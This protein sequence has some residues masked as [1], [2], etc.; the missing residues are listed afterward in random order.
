MISRLHCLFPLICFVACERSAV[1][2][3]TD[4]TATASTTVATTAVA[5]QN[6]PLSP[7]S[8][9]K[10]EDS[11]F[12]TFGIDSPDSSY[13]AW[14]RDG[15]VSGDHVR[16]PSGLLIIWLDTAVRAADGRPRR[17]HADSI[18]VAGLDPS[19]GLARFC[20]VNGNTS[21]AV[22]L[23]RDTATNHRPRLAWVFDEKTFRIKPTPTDSLVCFLRD[24]MEHDE[25][26]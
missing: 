6:V 2:Q 23:V 26:D 13:G 19:E 25:V 24:P 5:T 14:Y 15:F 22:G 20:A 18:V 21:H 8:Q 12:D 3:T 16:H 1:R 7:E 9:S 4:S 11:V 10:I 17:A